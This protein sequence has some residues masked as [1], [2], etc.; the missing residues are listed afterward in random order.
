MRNSMSIVFRAVIVGDWAG[1]QV[2]DI[3]QKYTHT[4]TNSDTA[5]RDDYPR[6]QRGASGPVGVYEVLQTLCYCCGGGNW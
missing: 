4:H 3:A 2:V 1:A 6:H 5:K